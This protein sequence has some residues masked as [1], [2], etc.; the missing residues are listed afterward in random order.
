[1]KLKKSQKLDLDGMAN[2][3]SNITITVTNPTPI[4]NVDNSISGSAK[5][6]RGRP[7]KNTV[8]VKESVENNIEAKEAA[9]EIVVNAP[10][11]ETPANQIV[12]EKIDEQPQQEQQQPS[13]V[14]VEVAEDK[15]SEPEVQEIIDENPTLTT[16]TTPSNE[17]AE[18]V[19]EAGENAVQEVIE[20]KKSSEPLEDKQETPKIDEKKDEQQLITFT[21]VEKSSELQMVEDKKPE[22][23]SKSIQMIVEE[24]AINKEDDIF[25]ITPPLIDDDESSIISVAESPKVVENEPEIATPVKDATFSPE[26]DTSIQDTRPHIDMTASSSTAITNNDTPQLKRPLRTSTPLAQRI[27]RNTPKI[28]LPV[29]SALKKVLSP[30]VANNEILNE[31]S[32]SETLNGQYKLIANNPL[33]RSILKSAHRKRSLSV[34]DCEKRVVFISPEVRQI[35]EIDQRMMQSF[36]EEK[37]NSIRQTTASS[38]LRRKRSLSDTSGTPGVKAKVKIPNFKAI[39]QMQFD[40]MESIAD[41][42]QRKAERA[43]RLVTP[44]KAPLPTVNEADS[45]IPLKKEESTKRPLAS[46]AVSM[47]EK[48]ANSQVKHELSKI[49]TAL[50]HRKPLTKIPSSMNKL[51]A[52]KN[53][54]RRSQSVDTVSAKA[55][56]VKKIDPYKKVTSVYGLARTH[57]ENK[58][59]IKFPSLQKSIASNTTS[60]SSTSSA[61]NMR[62]KIEERRDKNFGLYKSK[63]VQQQPKLDQRKKN[64]NLLKGVRLNRRFELQMQ[65]RR[66]LN[67]TVE[68]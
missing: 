19:I 62:T 13:E 35:E 44:S 64:E 37:E 6:P 68:D 53:R 38:G 17:I 40:K 7:R 9:I 65:H 1:M 48:S 10:E 63:N 26:V 28:S 46:S 15:S 34:T 42:A 18:S 67:D 56:A 31:E 3:K 2:H 45:K 60:T 24:T 12:A 58:P 39:H 33:E 61:Q 54:M 52:S 20:E 30:K 27:M 66:G 50:T 51:N 11:E 36:L 59:V 22:V 4:K 49:P 14:T 5:K 23:P 8:D 29:L 16:S 32:L 43:K 55:A 57:P 41:H 21:P 25:N 47:L